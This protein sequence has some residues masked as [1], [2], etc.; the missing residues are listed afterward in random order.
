MAVTL[1]GMESIKQVTPPF[2]D[3]PWRAKNSES[4]GLE[5]LIIGASHGVC[6]PVPGKGV[7]G[8]APAVGFGIRVMIRLFFPTWGTLHTGLG[9]GRQ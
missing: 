1:L 2:F 5:L 4:S 9:S 3:L 8:L 6:R 7:G